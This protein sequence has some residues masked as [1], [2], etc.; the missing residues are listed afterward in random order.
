MSANTPTPEKRSSGSAPSF[1]KNTH[2]YLYRLTGGVIGGKMGSRSLLLL[3]T[4]GRK[5]GKERVTPL[6]YL[7]DDNR[8]LLAASNYG[9]EQHPQWYL[10]LQANPKASVQIGKHIQTVTAQIAS[11]E[12]RPRLWARFTQ[13]SNFA[14]YERKT[15]REIP[16]VILTPVE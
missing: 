2:V 5:S 12:E 11:A 6:L 10:N 9:S 14:G 7:P 4:T 16:V 15:T 3:T 13:F 1:I 8:Y